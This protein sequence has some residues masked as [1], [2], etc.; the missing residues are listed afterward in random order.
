MS[1]TLEWSFVAG[2][3]DLLSLPRSTAERL[4]AAVIRFAQ[5]NRGPVERVAPHDPR[6]LRLVVPGAIAYMFADY[7]SGILLVGRVFR[8]G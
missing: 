1:W 6:R 7:E 2:R 3:H 5:T 4:D 8:R